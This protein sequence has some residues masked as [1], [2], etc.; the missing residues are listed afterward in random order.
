MVRG[1][2]D[3]STGLVEVS[4]P[5]TDN[6]G[7]NI[8]TAPE[9]NQAARWEGKLPLQPASERHH[10]IRQMELQKSPAH[11]PQSQITRGHQK[12]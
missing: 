1:E 4:S 10:T 7:L 8:L 12:L 5:D 3:K 11:V 2:T 9:M 6:R